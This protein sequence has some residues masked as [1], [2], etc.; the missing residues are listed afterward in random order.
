MLAYSYTLAY[1]LTGWPALVIRC[2]TD[3]RGL[4]IGLQIVARP[5]REDHCLALGAWLE[6][7]LHNHLGEFTGPR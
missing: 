3:A 1:N 5:F 2:G 4:P 6:T 7:V